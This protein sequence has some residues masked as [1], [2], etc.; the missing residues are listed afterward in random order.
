MSVALLLRQKLFT[1]YQNTSAADLAKAQPSPPLD[2]YRI[3][4]KFVLGLTEAG[5]A[6]V[7]V[8]TFNL[9]CGGHC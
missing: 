1:N 3:L 7:Y 5:K 8:H 9:Y 6:G 2:K 4:R